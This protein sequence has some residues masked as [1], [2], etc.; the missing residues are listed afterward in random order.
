M[1]SQASRETGVVQMQK[2]G[3]CIGKQN[4]LGSLKQKM[5]LDPSIP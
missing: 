5:T 4:S 3:S 1:Q 2:M